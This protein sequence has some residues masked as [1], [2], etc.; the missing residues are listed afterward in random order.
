M[1]RRRWNIPN[2]E[3]LEYRKI[4][5]RMR[6]AGADLDPSTLRTMETPWISLKCFRPASSVR[7]MP[8]GC[9]FVIY[10]T[11]V[12]LVSKVVLQDFRVMS[13]D[14]ALN[15][16]VLTD[17]SVCKS[18]AQFYL[19]LDRNRF[20]RDEVLNHRV[21]QAGILSRGEVL[22]GVLLAD[23]LGPVPEHYE[24]GSR[25]RVCL[26]ISNV[27]DE[28]QELTVDLLVERVRTRIRPR[29]ARRAGLLED[30]HLDASE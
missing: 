24:T 2:R 18:S 16:Y 29:T 19:L 8:G 20:H 5:E 3:L 28:I 12:A 7:V 26:S 22:E 21:D 9:V 4:A 1:P 25:I 15:P 6:A 10:L 30:A 17:P 13:P 27:F 11:I 14:W 23:S